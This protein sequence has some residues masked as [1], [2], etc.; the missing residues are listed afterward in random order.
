MT[1]TA[2]PVDWAT[3]MNN[4][5]NAYRNRIRGDRAENIEQAL[6]AYQQALTVMTQT[7]LPVDWAT[8]MNN[9]ATAYSDRIRVDRTADNI[10]GALAAITAQGLPG[11]IYTDQLQRPL[12]RPFYCSAYND[13]ERNALERDT[14]G[15]QEDRPNFDA[16]QALGFWRFYT[17][18][19]RNEEGLAINRI[20]IPAEKIYVPV[21]EWFW[22][23][24]P[25]R[26]LDPASCGG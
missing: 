20:E 11:G 19:P 13:P 26:C 12:P 3:T 25:N 18:L 17:I 22:N 7:A 10:A 4:L 21:D 16:S 6:A 24:D 15:S 23:A 9:L 14:D 8:T 2:L 5:A 1:Q